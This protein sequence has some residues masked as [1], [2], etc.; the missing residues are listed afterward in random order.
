MQYHLLSVVHTGKEHEFCRFKSLFRVQ[1]R[2]VDPTS[3]TAVPQLNAICQ[4]HCLKKWTT[5]VYTTVYTAAVVTVHVGAQVYDVN[6]HLASDCR[7]L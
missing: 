3:N 7:H 4:I 5:E 1:S 6:Q 2:A